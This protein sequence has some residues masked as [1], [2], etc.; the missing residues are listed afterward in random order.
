MVAMLPSKTI[1][2]TGPLVACSV[3]LSKRPP[4]VRFEKLDMHGAFPIAAMLEIIASGRVAEH[5]DA[6]VRIEKISPL[7]GQ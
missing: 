1:W 5:V 2:P 4:A 3:V 6:F 7:R